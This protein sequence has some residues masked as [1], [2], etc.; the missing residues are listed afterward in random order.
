MGTREDKIISEAR[1]TLNDLS[2]SNPRWSNNR[3]F[4]LLNDAQKDMCKAIPLI[5]RKTVINPV[6]GQIEYQLPLDSVKLL[7][8][9]YSGRAL[10]ITSEDE[11]ERDNIGWDDDY[12]GGF[13]HIIV[14]ELSQQT[15]RPYPM[16]SVD[17][18][19]TPMKTR[20]QAMPV[21]LGWEDDAIVNELE[22]NS[23]WDLALK[24][25]V[26]G[27]AFIDYGDESSVSRSQLAIGIYNKE[28][29]LAKKLAKKAFAKRVRTTEFQGKVSHRNTR[30]GRYGS[31][32]RPRY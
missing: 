9:T 8:A 14:N 21:D 18:T 3:L 6:V 2:V 29:T 5:T 16:L 23:M 25:Y 32:C 11:I 12:S 19:P 13:T 4:E 20:Y 31:N 28:Y 7:T 17:S 10:T 24:Q 30:G 27:M 15:I 26:I 22:I 1:V